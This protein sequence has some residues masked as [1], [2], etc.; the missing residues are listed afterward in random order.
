M[1]INNEYKHF[2]ISLSVP[3]G[4]RCLSVPNPQG[5]GKDD[6]GNLTK[7]RKADYCTEN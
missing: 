2:Y 6:S 5:D 4:L 7:N 1:L 3:C